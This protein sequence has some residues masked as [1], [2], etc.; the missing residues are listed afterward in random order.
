MRAV[1]QRVV[2]ASVRVGG[3]PVARI[4]RGFVVLLGVSA[5]DAQGDADTL[6]EKVAHLRIVSDDAGKMNR[7]ILDAGGEVLSVPQFTLYADTGRGRRPSFVQAAAPEQAA[8]LYERF[9]E[10][11]RG[12]GV[13]VR[14]GT[15]RAMMVVEIHNDGPVTIVLDTEMEPGSGQRGIT[16]SRPDPSQS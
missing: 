2:E 8:P 1:V 9:N 12:L 11:L 7:S 10:R 4:G 13:P 16:G 6:A 14:T 15:F 5:S 3:E